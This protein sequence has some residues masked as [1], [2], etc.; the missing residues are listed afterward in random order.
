[1]IDDVLSELD[2]NRKQKLLDYLQRA[3][4]QSFLTAVSLGDLKCP[5]GI[6]KQV[7]GGQI[8]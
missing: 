3:E 5:Q 7:A 6:V 1:M 4:F 2:E 8:R